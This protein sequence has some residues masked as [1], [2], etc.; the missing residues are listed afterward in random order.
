MF[1]VHAT[2]RD[3]SPVS[4]AFRKSPWR[5]APGTQHSRVMKSLLPL[6][7]V[8]LCAVPGANAQTA[9]PIDSTAPWAANNRSWSSEVGQTWSN[10]SLR[11]VLLD[12]VRQDQEARR[13]YGSRHA[14]TT[15]LRELLETDRRLSASVDVILD[16]F[17]LPTRSLVG[18]AGASALFLVVLHSETLQR[19]V[20][21]MAKQVAAGEL[22]PSSLATLEDRVLVS[23][24][25][26]QRFAT[27]FA[28]GPDGSVKFAAVDDPAGVAQ[29]RTDAGL[30]PLAVYI[31]LIEEDGLKVD[32]RT[33]PPS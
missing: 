32:R 13:G 24:G 31:C 16:R 9:C 8:T 27:Q 5:S 4:A 22:P 20:L 18:A 3:H 11:R 21:A 1:R 23:E 6:L 15:Y 17:G 10:D 29:R 2:F 12:L 30:P 28:I 7:I 33:L 19:R 25:K 14:D 26:S